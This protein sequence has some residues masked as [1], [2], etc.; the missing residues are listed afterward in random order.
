VE[1]RWGPLSGDLG[2]QITDLQ[3]ANCCAVFHTCVFPAR[4]ICFTCPFL[5]GFWSKCIICSKCILINA[6]QVR[7]W[8]S[9]GDPLAVMHGHTQIANCCAFTPDGRGVHPHPSIPPSLNSSIPQIPVGPKVDGF[10]LQTQLDNL[11]IVRQQ[12]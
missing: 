5:L 1:Q 4:V 3:I 7:V 6:K 9:D 11:G 10:V 2:T 8:S 12:R